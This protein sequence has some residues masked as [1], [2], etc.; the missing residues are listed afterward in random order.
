MTVIKNLQ[1]SVGGFFITG[2]VSLLEPCTM[3]FPNPVV[4]AIGC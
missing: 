1:L 2:T 3:L 4:I